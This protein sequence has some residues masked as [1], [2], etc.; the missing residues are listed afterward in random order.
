MRLVEVNG[1]DHRRHLNGRGTRNTM[2]LMRKAVRRATPR[3]VK[4]VKRVVKHPARTAVR[5]ATP[6][7]IRKAQ[8]QVFN[9]THPVN[10]VENAIIDNV[11]PRRPA[12]SKSRSARSTGAG[13]QRTTVVRQPGPTARRAASAGPRSSQAANER[14]VLAQRI[15]EF[16]A[17]L[18]SRHLGQ[19]K[20]PAALVVEPVQTPDSTRVRQAYALRA[21]IPGLEQELAPFGMPPVA[22]VFEPPEV[23][24]VAAEV[25]ATATANVSRLRFGERRRLKAATAQ[26]AQ[27]LVETKERELSEAHDRQQADLD[28]KARRLG[29]LH[30][31]VDAEVDAWVLEQRREAEAVHARDVANAHAW[32]KRL[33]AN[34]PTTVTQALGPASCG[35]HVQVTAVQG[36]VV[37]LV[38]KMAVPDGWL[39][40]QEACLTAAGRPT[41]KKRSA[42]SLNVLYGGA[43]ASEV[44]RLCKLAF[45]R[46]PSITAVRIAV[47]QTGHDAPV[48]YGRFERD[49]PMVWNLRSETPE[50]LLAAISTADDVRI[51]STN[52]THE[53]RPVNLG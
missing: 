7:P 10:T 19:F 24:E 25:Y 3:P 17:G 49:R 41:L 16:E 14:A 33:S 8:R 35:E 45:E 9:V 18:L 37:D 21:G 11:M 6:K 43:L 27:G 13:T 36:S 12:Q 50:D 53:L 2:G 29:E 51:N 42:T 22:P 30:H 40:A 32:S 15:Q 26:Q 46:V 4:Q 47:V 39:P 23:A 52:R 34:D 44:L 31:S 48:Y 20:R 38:V 1:A 28:Q 5:A